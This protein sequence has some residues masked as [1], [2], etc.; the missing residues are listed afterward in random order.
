MPERFGDMKAEKKLTDTNYLTFSFR[1][2]RE[3][4]DELNKLIQKTLD[5]LNRQL[6]SDDKKI[7]KNRLIIDAIKIGLKEV[8]LESGK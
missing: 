5:R 3:A 8:E 7:R 1:I 6:G 4:K 2:S